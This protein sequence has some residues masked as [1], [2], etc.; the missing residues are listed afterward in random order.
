MMRTLGRDADRLLG[1]VPKLLRVSETEK[2][3][4]LRPSTR[5]EEQRNVTTGKTVDE[6]RSRSFDQTVNPDRTGFPIYEVCRRRNNRS[7]NGKTGGPMFGRSID[8][9]L[10]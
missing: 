6:A 8:G 10:S 2:R 4:A 9:P 1:I 3:T 5:G 7:L